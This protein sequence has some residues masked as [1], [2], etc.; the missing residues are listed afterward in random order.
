MG[1][2]VYHDLSGIS[3]KSSPFDEAVLEVARSGAVGIVS[4]YIG[5]DYLQRVIQVSAGWRLISDIEAWLSSLS[6]RSRP[7]AWLFIRENLD[8]IHHYPAIHAKAVIGQQLAMFGS[9]NLT[10][11]GIL[12][13][14]EL[15]ILIDDP[16]MVAELGG[17]FETLWQQ[18]QPPIAD[19]TSAFIQWLDEEAERSPMRREKFSLSASSKKIRSHLVKLQS[20]TALELEGA[21]LNLDSIAQTLIIQEQRHYDSLEDALESAINVLAV[22]SDSF[23]FAQIVTHVRQAFPTT[24]MREIYFALLQH[25]ANHVRSVFTENTRNRLVLIDDRFTQSTK[26]TLPPALAPFD[27]FLSHLVHLFDFNQARDLPDEEIIERQTGILGRDQVTLISELTDCGFLD[28]EDVAGHLPLYRLSEDFAWEGRYKLFTT[29]MHDWITKKNRPA[30]ITEE[31]V[32]TDTKDYP[33]SEFSLGHL[34]D[35]ANIFDES[36]TPSFEYRNLKTDSRSANAEHERVK[37]E[38]RAKI[39]MVL[40]NVLAR[41]FAG[42]RLTS[43]RYFSEQLS[44]ELGIGQKLVQLII[45]GQG[46][47]MPKVILTTQNVIT[48]NPRLDWKDLADYPL[49]QNV[50]KSFLEKSIPETPST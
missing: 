27:K 2:L 49:T 20:P 19:E 17:W 10:N 15:G 1:R 21:P 42:N 24:I 11:T 6:M 18:T 31:S 29:A 22:S 13:R 40:A 41:L 37:Q 7:K 47:E 8:C 5:V 36:D 23:S 16:T 44:E 4:P 9:A 30:Q 50:C 28:I 48:I 34:P 46:K 45:S 26:E 39:D 33:S 35:V 14:T 38:R 25:C 43:T 12:G 32:S 3:G